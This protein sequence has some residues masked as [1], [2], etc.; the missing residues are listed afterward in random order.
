MDKTKLDF[1]SAITD[2]LAWPLL[3]LV[4][5]QMFRNNV[6]EL[7]H[8]VTSVKHGETEMTFA[9]QSKQ[10]LAGNLT[11]AEEDEIKCQQVVTTN[12]HY[13]LYANGT[14][15]QRV[16]VTSRPGETDTVVF[17]ITFPNEAITVQVIGDTGA[18]VIEITPGN[19]KIAYP[20]NDA[21][22]TFRLL[23]SGI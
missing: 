13:T 6:K 20:P 18:R 21:R 22:Q 23:I 16:S 8:R 11:D 7:L 4:L 9:E 3:V 12:E 5:V 15:V 17:P 19:C 2:H 10:K 1:I 14:F